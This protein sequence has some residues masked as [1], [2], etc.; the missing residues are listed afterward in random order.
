MTTRLARVGAGTAAL[1][2][3]LSFGATAGNAAATS[4]DAKAVTGQIL[5]RVNG[6][7]AAVRADNGAVVRTYSNTIDGKW[8]PNKTRLA[9]TQPV[10]YD[11]G[12]GVMNADGTGRTI[13][14]NRLPEDK[15][16]FSADG[17]W[18]IYSECNNPYSEFVCDIYR[19]KSTA[20]FGAPVKITNAQWQPTTGPCAGYE[21]EYYLWAAWKPNSRLIAVT[22]GCYNPNGHK[23]IPEVVNVDTRAV[24]ARGTF[25]GENATWSPD[26][27]RIAWTE[28][29]PTSA[30][31]VTSADLKTGFRLTS[32]SAPEAMS[33]RWPAW[34]PDSTR[35]AW[36][37]GWSMTNRI[38]H[39]AAT[40][41]AP[42]TVVKTAP[43]NTTLPVLDW[44]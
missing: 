17:Q 35:V 44:K 28:W 43:N 8:S 30:I 26:G 37:R 24:I 38:V 13:I 32:P 16:S 29:A 4:D 20:P 11:I 42:V 6:D 18:I 36:T 15:P 33:G 19:I 7:L 41:G 12:M 14:P 40:A 34:S 27:K 23:S 22:H 39:S 1:A 2:G 9:Y 25:S 10:N 31:R 3:L 5:A 21:A